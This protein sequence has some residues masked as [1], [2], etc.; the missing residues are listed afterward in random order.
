MIIYMEIKKTLNNNEL[1]IKLI[2]ELNSYTAP[3][4][5]AVIKNDLNGVSSLI[6]DFSELS[7]LSSAGLRILLVAQKVMQKQGKM[8]LVHVNESVMEILEIT[9][10]SNVLNIEA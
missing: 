2:G 6:F 10:F 7:Y 9:G 4:M 3:E 5:E 1:T 8:T